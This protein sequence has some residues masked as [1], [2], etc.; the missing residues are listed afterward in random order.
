[1]GDQL[2]L[3]KPLGTGI[4]ATALKFNR[5]SDLQVDGAVE[6]MVRLNRDAADTLRTLPAGIVSACTDVT[7][8]GLA[9]LDRRWRPRAA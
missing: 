2:L 1:V 5:A 6:S 9:G 3:T 7:G 8:F 4:I